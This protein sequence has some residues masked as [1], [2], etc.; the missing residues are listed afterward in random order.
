MPYLSCDYTKEMATLPKT[1]VNEPTKRKS[2]WTNDLE[3][4]ATIKGE[5]PARANRR[6]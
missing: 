1:R 3:V 2:R 5:R 6:R 4:F